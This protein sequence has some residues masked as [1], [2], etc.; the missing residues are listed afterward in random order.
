MEKKPYD[1]ERLSQR[2]IAAI[3]GVTARTIQNWGKPEN[4][5]ERAGRIPRNA[6]GT[7][8]SAAV[9]YWVMAFGMLAR[10]ERS[11]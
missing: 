3:L 5:P 2:E 7:Y 4:V 6:D 10:V 9:I 1:L 8:H 11:R